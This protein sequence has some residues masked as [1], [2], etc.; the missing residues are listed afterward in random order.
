MMRRG[1]VLIAV[2]A[3]GLMSA[4]LAA[5]VTGRIVRTGPFQGAGQMI[6]P[7][8]W[9]FV[10]VELRYN[11][12]APLDAELRLDQRDRDGDIVTA[13]T[14]APLNPNG[15]PR[16]LFIYFMPQ[17]I[18]SGDT[19]KV[20]LVDHEAKPIKILDGT[21][22]EMSHLQSEPVF[23]ESPESF[24]VADLTGPR[25]SA[26]A[27]WI[28]T[29]RSGHAPE[30]RHRRIVRPLAPAELP[31]RWQGLAGIDAIV[32]DDADPG[33]ATPQQLEMLV[34]WV[35]N[36]GRLL[37]TCGRTWQAVAKSP[38]AEILPVTLTGSTS[39]TQAL[40]FHSLVGEE[41][42][43]QLKL[44][45]RYLKN[46]ITRCTMIPQVG[47]IPIPREC[48]NPQIAHRRIVGRGQITFVG[49]SLQQLLP[50]PTKLLAENDPDSVAFETDPKDDPFIRTCRLLV[51]QNFLALPLER[52]PSEHH[53]IQRPSDLFNNTLRRTIDFGAQ[54]VGFLAFAM[55][56]AIIYGLAAT[57]GSY[58]YLRK[59]GWAQHAWSVFAG[60]AVIASFIGT[61]TVWGLRGFNTRLMQTNVIDMAAGYD[62]ARGACLLG[63]KSPNHARFDL[64]LPMMST[65]A[66]Q[67]TPPTVITP[68]PDIQS[69]DTLSTSFVAP[70]EYR[71]TGDGGRIEGVPLRAT[72]KEFY[73][74]WHGPVGGTVDGKLIT[75]AGASPGDSAQLD[76]DDASFIQNNLGVDLRQCYLLET[77]NDT[78]TQTSSV[79]PSGQVYCHEL[80]SIPASGR[81]D[82]AT[83]RT[84]M[85]F[86]PPDPNN[87]GAPPKRKPSRFLATTATQW[88]NTVMP[89]L[90]EALTGTQSKDKLMPGHEHAAMLLLSVFNLIGDWSD[91]QNTGLIVTRSVG[92]NLDC[93]HELTSQ[94]AVLL[95]YADQPTAAT[96]EVDRTALQPTK[97]YTMYRIVI[98][99]E[100]R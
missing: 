32:W 49:A 60:L 51:A 6:R 53:F 42:A 57:F 77:R 18:T 3:I 24:V 43:T 94:T 27:A 59:R 97:S 67:E 50:P 46:P 38:L 52:P 11:G 39:T 96:L 23:L 88:R 81:L 44:E 22:E 7:G 74:L 89:T 78:P 20:T 37:L 100:R 56:F 66:D 91:S 84:A 71:L 25:K 30:S 64:T 14:P 45:R 55:L 70:D 93:S 65:G 69:L 17:A 10:E 87:P 21:G 13:A 33:S 31:T 28:D 9:T 58:W 40:E 72:L 54:S 26:H 41:V 80:G 76:L 1:G 92:R 16:R 75:H 98:P 61:L 68:M 86:E 73:G 34:E 5:Q 2:I 12:T 63:L 82:A 35:K 62:A 47:A 99:V 15:D 85:F 36:G 83:L 79:N 29:V 8:S 4:P 90:T 48:A 19:I 95:G